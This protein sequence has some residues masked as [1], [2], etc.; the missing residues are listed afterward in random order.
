MANIAFDFLTESFLFDEKYIEDMF[1]KVSEEELY[2]ELQ[3]YRE[4]IQ[5]NFSDIV[6]EI[7][8]KNG[9]NVSIESAG[10]LPNEQL[11]KQLALYM[12]RVVIADP[13][14]QFTAIKSDMNKPMNKLMGVN[15]NCEI[16]RIQLAR[17]AKYMRWTT[18]L[19]VTQ[20]AK[21]V[22]ISLIHEAPK[23]LPIVYS[24]NNF[25]SELSEDLYKFFL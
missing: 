15:T 24:S 20:F 6:D 5:K 9:L 8:S 14:F 22:P 25:S 2:L 12:D 3:K 1:R 13:I 19:V 10:K 17:N 18:P 16:D 21:Y 11:L 23:E 4:H 7:K